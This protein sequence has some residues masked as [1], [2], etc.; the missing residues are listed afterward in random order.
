MEFFRQSTGKWR[1]QRTTHHLAFRRSES[2][3]SAIS[4]E[5]LTADHPKVLEIC[6]LHEVD[7]ALA[8]GGALVTWQSSMEWDQGN[9]S[10][11]GSTVFVLVPDA[12][13]A[14]Q[15]KL[16]RERGYAEIVPVIGQYHMDDEGALV[17]A[18]E[19]GMS[20]TAERFW[21]AGPDLR[22]R[23]SSVQGTMGSTATFCTEFRVTEGDEAAIASA[24]P[25][26]YFS[27]FGG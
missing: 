26:K 6:Q 14:P 20:V 15:G 24:E 21:F 17:L 11:E 13:D 10:H 9:D 19:Y 23:T 27:F 22:M 16:L 4:V 7:P 18:T 12:P 1:S 3:E 8:I 5:A 2:G 25:A